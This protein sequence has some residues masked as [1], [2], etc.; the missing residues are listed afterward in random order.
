MNR[1]ESVLESCFEFLVLVATKLGEWSRK[2]K[3]SSNGKIRGKPAQYLV[4]RKKKKGGR[5]KKDAKRRKAH[6]CSSCR[7]RSRA[8]MG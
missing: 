2:K 8:R 4:G 3:N 5:A 6:G 7:K 1:K